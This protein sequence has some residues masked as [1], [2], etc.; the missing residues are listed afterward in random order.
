M[1]QESQPESLPFL[2]PGA[3][4]GMKREQ[5]SFVGPALPRP[6]LGRQVDH[7]SSRGAKSPTPTT[8]QTS[9]P[10]DFRARRTVYV[11]TEE[12]G[13]KTPKLVSQTLQS[14]QAAPAVMLLFG[15]IFLYRQRS[16]GCA[17]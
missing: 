8:T 4:S 10:L 14:L 11:A 17:Q 1:Y 13:G 5:P 12:A 15:C 6:P 16:I 3:N 7:L 2:L 9:P